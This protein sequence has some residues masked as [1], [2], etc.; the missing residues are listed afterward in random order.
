MYKDPLVIVHG[1]G[2]AFTGNVNQVI[3]NPKKAPF[4]IIKNITL[5]TIRTNRSHVNGYVRGSTVGA[6]ETLT[7]ET[8]CFLFDDNVAIL[9]TNCLGWNSIGSTST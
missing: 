5:T 7:V 6:L 1:V 8:A 4:M 3:G 2:G 9:Y